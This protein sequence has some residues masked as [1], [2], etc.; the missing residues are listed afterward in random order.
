MDRPDPALTQIALEA[1]QAAARGDRE[2]LERLCAPGMVWEASGR[3][4]WAG[5]RKGLDEVFAYLAALGE[6]SDEFFSELQDVLV[7]DRRA[8]VLFHVSGRR[9][10]KALETDFIL[11][12]DIEG[13]RITRIHSVPRDQLAVDEFWA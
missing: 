2:T 12:F 6:A 8:A 9:E 10:G 4:R 3:G 11:L 7:S 1:W 5:A 13:G